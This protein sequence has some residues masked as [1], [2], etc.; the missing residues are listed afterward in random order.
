MFL[1]ISNK[2]RLPREC[3][4]MVGLS[5]KRGRTEDRVTIGQFGSGV[6]YAAA[7]ALR[8]GMHTGITSTDARGAYYLSFDSE[9]IQP[10][11]YDAH[12]RIVYQYYAKDGTTVPPT[13]RKDYRHATDRTVEAF[14]DWDKPVGNDDKRRFKILREHVCNAYDEDKAFTFS[15]V[16]RTVLAKP[17]EAAV[18]LTDDK[19]FHDMLV[20]FPARYFKFLSGRKPIHVDPNVGEIWTKS[21]KRKTRSFLRGVLV[22]CTSDPEAASIFDYSLYEKRL[23]SEERILKSQLDFQ[24]R[25]SQ[26]FARLENKHIIRCILRAVANGKAPYEAAV[27]ARTV[28]FLFIESSLAAWQQVARELF[29]EKLAL[30]CGNPHDDE[31]ARQVMGYQV[32]VNLP[33]ALRYFLQYLGF[34]KA[35]EV[36]PKMAN[37]EWRPVRIDDLPVKERAK[38][39]RAYRLFSERF[40]EEAAYPI[41]LFYPLS[42]RMRNAGLA[43][44]IDGKFSQIWIAVNEDLTL[45][46]EHDVYET[47]VHEGRHC[48]ANADDIDRAFVN[49]ADR[50]IA[51]L[52]YAAAGYA[53]FPGTDIVVRR[54]GMPRQPKFVPQVPSDAIRVDIEGDITDITDDLDTLAVQDEKKP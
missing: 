50:D 52:T 31:N 27:L 1:K 46:P 24:S 32:P 54:L 42:E 4:E 2:G 35:N 16:D 39:H 41:Q 29:G 40:P 38:F 19:E 44:K 9:S 11:G 43:P 33:D 7:A 22:G 37:D 47:L 8:M 49:K 6:K 48:V 26:M 17:D 53:K 21:G 25:I 36:L 14:P 15:F 28:H 13:A 18:Y 34:P 23:L 12:R 5:S 30:P 51:H 45:P 20:E 10:E 3:L